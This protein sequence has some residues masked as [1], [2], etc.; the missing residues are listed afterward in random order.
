MQ[1]EAT[2]TAAATRVDLRPFGDRRCNSPLKGGKGKDKMK[3][4]VE[5]RQAMI[6]LD[7]SVGLQL[8]FH[9]SAGLLVTLGAPSVHLK[10][11]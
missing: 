9:P 6:G 3:C 10:P 11:L 8:A 2:L 7:W 5:H 1:T 4:E